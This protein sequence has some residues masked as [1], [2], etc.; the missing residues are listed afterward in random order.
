MMSFQFPSWECSPVITCKDQLKSEFDKVGGFD[1]SRG[2]TDDWS[3]SE[4]LGYKAQAV[5]GV[6]FYHKNPDSPLEVFKQARWV[7]KRPYKLGTV[8]S[9]YALLRSSFPA[10]ICVGFWKALFNEKPFFI[11]FKVVY[12]FGVFIGIIE[13]LLFGKVSK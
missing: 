3:L 13:Y 8:G 7:G 12:D 9:I 1:P 11:V 2:Y 6:I 10:S 4:K 5:S